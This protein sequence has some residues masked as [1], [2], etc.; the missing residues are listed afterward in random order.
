VYVSRKAAI[1][2]VAIVIILSGGECRAGSEYKAN[3]LWRCGSSDEPVYSMYRSDMWSIPLGLYGVM[4]LEDYGVLVTDEI[5]EKLIRVKPDG[6]ES[7]AVGSVGEGPEDHR[8]RCEPIK[9]PGFDLAMSCCGTHSKVLGYSKEGSL[10]GFVELKDSGR[11]YVRILGCAEFGVGVSLAFNGSPMSGMAV[12][13]FVEVLSARGEVTTE[14]LIGMYELPPAMQ[15][16]V[17]SETLFEIVPR[18]A[19]SQFGYIYIQKDPYEWAV[20]CYDRELNLLWTDKRD[21]EKQYRT[22]DILEQ[23]RRASGGM[24]PSGVEHVIGGL[25]PVGEGELWVMSYGI[26]RHGVGVREFKLL[27]SKGI[28]KGDVIVEGFY[29]SPGVVTISGSTAVWMADN[30]WGVDEEG[31]GAVPL[32]VVYHLEEK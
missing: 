24:K 18:V 4:A 29:A 17:V 13:V 7:F 20:D 15:G 22:P 11:N 23:R 26:S 8:G 19:V 3:E 32:I 6:I 16:E 21:V 10:S 27:D 25:F 31:G 2:V 12:D 28:L 9:W 5:S 1:A 14:Q 30:T